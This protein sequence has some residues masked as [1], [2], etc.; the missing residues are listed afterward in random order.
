M[1]RLFTSII[2]L[3]AVGTITPVAAIT[4]DIDVDT[5]F[6]NVADSVHMSHTPMTF[7][8]QVEIRALLFKWKFKTSATQGDD[9]LH[10]DVGSGAPSWISDGVFTDL[11]D[12]Q[13]TLHAFDLQL[14][15]E[16]QGV[17]DQRFYVISGVRNDGKE[18][19]ALSGKLWIDADDWYIA[20]AELA[21]TWG[22]LEVQQQ[23]RIED[24]LRVLHRQEGIARAWISARIDIDYGHYWFEK[25]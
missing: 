5:I 3:L 25:H 24:G 8:Q 18:S 16:E 20:K 12:I 7:E 6:R 4:A 23:Y 1:H 11:V 10:V 2:V 13:G 15:G 19:G 21:Y 22:K 14:Q 17:N 9:G